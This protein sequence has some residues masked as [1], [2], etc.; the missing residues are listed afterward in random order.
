MSFLISFIYI[1]FFTCNLVIFTKRK[2]GEC[3]PLTLMI[4]AFSMF[5]SQFIFKT[6]QVGFALNV[7]FAFFFLGMLIYKF[8]K[9]KMKEVK[10]NIFTNGFYFFLVIFAIVL[11]WDINRCFSGWDEFSHWGQ[12]L[13]EMLR[14]DSF[15]SI[16]ESVLLVHKDYPPI[17]Q[18]YELFFCKL[19]GYSE[20]LILT[21]FHVFNFSLFI[22][23]ISEHISFTKGINWLKTLAKYFFIIGNV[24]L[25][26]LLFDGH[27][28]IN[29]I[30]IDY[31]MSI[32]IAYILS[33]IVKKERLEK[34]DYI[35]LSLSCSFLLLM[36]QMGLPLYLMV[37]FLLFSILFF[38]NY[39]M[40][41]L[42]NIRKNLKNILLFIVVIIIIPL[43]FYKGWNVYIDRLGI[44]GQFEISDIHIA[45]LPR[46]I[47][48]ELEPYQTITYRNYI[49][50]LKSHTMSTSEIFSFTYFGSIAL[51]IISLI[52]IAWKCKKYINEKRINLLIVTLIIGSIGYAFTMMVLYIFSFGEREG[53]ALASFNRYLPTYILIVLFVS[54]MLY[55][56]C[57]SRKEEESKKVSVQSI[58]IITLILLIFQNLDYIPKVLPKIHKSPESIQEKYAKTIASKTEEDDKVF[59]VAQDTVSEYQFYIGYH[60]GARNINLINY[61]WPIGEDKK[62]KWNAIHEELQQY[63][64]LFLAVIND[65]FIKE[66]S[67]L[68]SNKKDIVENN[69]FKI[70][71]KDGKIKFIK[72]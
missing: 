35:S 60:V 20:N 34:F 41:T 10:S 59:V 44:V 30:Y 64:Y 42:K 37:L 19:C 55:I 15:Y 14:L 53:P 71:N 46:V 36:K 39:K 45:D 5:F 43:S 11:V 2:F 61:S 32:L 13:K 26:L 1:V 65:D 57:Q 8:K 56:F 68:F 27:S 29:T 49:D 31:F 52:V 62:E 7:L 21:I 9:K 23:M 28:I 22:P 66:Y 25:L 69:I 12:M 50:V 63:D 51:G 40:I 24:L 38:E 67:Y 70:E 72:I 33:I 4:T 6:F 58:F 16:K 17:V 47:N 3:L 48:G 18:L 54:F